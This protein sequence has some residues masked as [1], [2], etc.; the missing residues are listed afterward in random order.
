[1]ER[2]SGRERSEI[3]AGNGNHHDNMLLECWGREIVV[4]IRPLWRRAFSV[5]VY[6]LF[7]FLQSQSQKIQSESILGL[8]LIGGAGNFCF[9]KLDC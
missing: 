7:S 8:R 5:L 2:F 6:F 1:M 4:M 3:C 9:Q